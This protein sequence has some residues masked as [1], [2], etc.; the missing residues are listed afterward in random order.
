VLR[1]SGPLQHGDRGRQ[2]PSSRGLPARV[3]S[4]MSLAKAGPEGCAAIPRNFSVPFL[5][6]LDRCCMAA[7]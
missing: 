4:R 1:G 2:Y 3:L 7:A 5:C 6:P